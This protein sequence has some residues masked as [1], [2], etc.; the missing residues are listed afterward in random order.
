MIK[1]LEENS[2]ARHVGKDFLKRPK[3]TGNKEE[4]WLVGLHQAMK[5]VNCQENSESEARANGVGEDICK[6]CNWW[7]TN[8]QD[9][10]R[11]KEIQQ[12]PNTPVKIWA[13]YQ[14]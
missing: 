3:S 7:S 1:L 6:Q 11:V 10:Q 8:I 12:T 14:T 2:R 13:F 9:Q 5:F 4:N